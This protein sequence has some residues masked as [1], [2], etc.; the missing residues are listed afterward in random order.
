M[1]SNVQ[2]QPAPV[3]QPCEFKT[4]FHPRSGRQALYQC[5]EEFGIAP[6]TQALPADEEPWRPFRSR[7]DFEFSE[8]ALDAALNKH[9]IDR[10]LSLIARISQ[11][12]TQITLTN[13][14]DLRKAL[15]NA[16]S[17]L[18]P[19]TKH[20][21]KVPYK[22][23]ERVYEVHA[24]PLWD[25]ALDLLDNPLL[26]PHFVWDAQRVYKHNGMD[27]EHF[28]NEPWTGH[29][30]WDIQSRL[31]PD[32]NAVPF[33][34]I[35]YADKTRLSSHGTVK[36]YPVVARCANLPVEIRNG[37]GL[38][39]GQVVTNYAS[40]EGKHGYTT[41]KR[42]VW[43][44]S[45]LKLLVH[46]D[47][48]SKTGYSYSCYDKIMRWLF[49][50]IL[51]LSGDYEE[52][53]MMSLIRGLQCKCPCPVCLVPLDELHDLSKTFPIRSMKDAQVALDIYRQN[54]TE[55]E[56]VLKGLGLRPVA[57]ALWLIENSD[58]HEALS[59]DDLHTLHGGTGGVH[60]L[61][62]LKMVL[63]DLGH[64]A[65]D[66][67]KQQVADFPRWRA[68][69]HFTTVIHITFSNGNKRWDLVKISFYAALSVLKC[70][71]S[72]EGY[73]LLRVIRSYLRLDSLI[74]LDVHT[75]R[76]L[77]MIDAEFL[78]Y[79]TALKDYIEYATTTSSIEGIKTDWNFPK[80]HLW[81]HARRDIESKGVARNYSTRPNEKLH[82][83]LK[84][85]YLSQSNGK[86]VAKQILR[87]DHHKCAALLLRGRL[88]TLDE[89]CRLQA[90]GDAGL[91][92]EDHDH[93]NLDGHFKLGSPQSRADTIQDIEN[94]LS[95]QDSAF[96]GF[97]KKLANF[98]NTSLPTYGY[99]LTRWT[100]IPTDFQIREYCYLKLNYE[101]TVNWRQS[102]D[103]LRSNPSFHGS[104]RFD[105]ALIQLTAERTVFVKIIFMFKCEV[106]DIGAFQFALVQP[107]TAGIP[108]GSRRIDQD[109]RLT[110]VK[111][112]PRKDSIFVPLK[113]FIRGAV[114]ACDPEHQDEFLV[115]EHID[116]D[117]FL[118][119]EA[120]AC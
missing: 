25:W 40:K 111:A 81:K 62:E 72:P 97:R 93:I 68:L 17:E 71:V 79:D 116:S 117:M 70:Q 52:Q 34:F 12:Q 87:I 65:Q 2:P 33:C 103:H 98:I 47:Q 48:Y 29:R 31:L 118:R 74:G 78:V 109:L 50:V 24:R 27:F 30:W 105:C 44:E 21:I 37:E 13:E 4:E 45:F 18:T 119:M 8:I 59:L 88:D 57:N 51:I 108:G 83:P 1:T 16:A 42:V 43:H 113:S 104:P 101:S 58:P 36:G 55:G 41:L 91:D 20:E 115:V 10:L 82:G 114:L 95:A 89:Q 7:G 73:R 75:E 46:L 22:K 90:L 9:Q 102:T 11:G 15:D 5:F 56:E 92:D 85:A 94:R 76:T 28:F 99:Q 120:R 63:A 96:Q 86:D 35:L 38:G 61:R 6:E 19:F 100:I 64:K 112:V 49:P 39:G 67:F 69:T 3:D 80:T 106:P 14:T 54:R 26:A 110:R 23:E 66:D 53:C 107:Y 77:A 32:L 84:S 60:L